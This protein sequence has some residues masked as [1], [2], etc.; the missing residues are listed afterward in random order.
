MKK[1]LTESVRVRK[2]TLKQAREYC[3]YNDLMLTSFVT[4][5]IKEKL[6]KLLND[7]KN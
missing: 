1:K 5:A 3:E 6:E 2:N 4:A 7:N